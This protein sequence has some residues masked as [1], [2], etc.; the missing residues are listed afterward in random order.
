[1]YQ[2][3]C[4]ECHGPTGRGDGRKAKG[5][6][7][8]PPSN[9]ADPL[10]MGDAA[11]VDVF[12]RI[13]IG[14]PGT[15]MPEFEEDLP[16]DDR[17]A[18]TA[19]VLTLSGRPGIVQ[20]AAADVF[21]TVRRQVDSA[22]AQRSERL[23]FNAYLTFEQVETD[24]RAKQSRLASQLEDGF[25]TLRGRIATAPPEELAA[26]ARRLLADVERAERV[27]AD[28][29]S[30]ANLFAQSLI[31][32]VREGFEAILIIGALMAFLTR[33]GASARR[34]D[35]ARGAWGAVA[36]SVVTWALVQFLFHITPAQREAI[37]G[38]T[39]L[40]AMAVLFYVSYWLLSKIE[41][42]RWHAFVKGKMEAALSTGSG[43]ALAAVAFLAVYREGFE[44][45]LF[46]EALLSSAGRS[47][48][49]PVLGGI[50]AGAVALV[51]V[52]VAVIRFGLRL[53]MKPF[54]AVTS[55]VLYYMAFVFAG[56]GI[57]ELQEGGV[58]GTTVLHWA[59]RWP[60]LGI[61]PTV[62]S[63]TLQG[64][65][66]VLLV[67]GLV[68]TFVFEPRRL[69]VTNQLV[70]EPAKALETGDVAVGERT[71]RWESD[72]VRSLERMDADLAELRA[73]VDR[74]KGLLLRSA[75]APED[76]A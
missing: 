19:Y 29:G 69:Q 4:A 57:A 30:A 67:A 56:K 61:Y 64:L 1:M 12:R 33:A 26:L 5:L 15:G 63:L 70:P 28:R 24:V 42:A 58:V 17:W 49:A 76:K 16:I 3:A 59:P 39:M 38:F 35:V 34:R 32:M 52:Y 21:A 44:T 60:A 73:E 31:L 72:M 74:L 2:A 36:A 48:L 22:V 6:K 14:V 53:P 68:W 47:G 10:V 75:R 71:P 23:A 9:L 7:G 45:I 8:P 66:V 11:P 51:G 40:L 13:T 62:E 20:A 46:Y 25:A 43:V 54:F 65:L 50:G 41:V 37:E 27:V 55:A 18:V